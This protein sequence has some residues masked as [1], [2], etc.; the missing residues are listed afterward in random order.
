M[1]CHV[2]VILC[3]VYF[4][5]CLCDDNVYKFSN[6]QNTNT[7]SLLIVYQ[8]SKNLILINVINVFAFKDTLF[9]ACISSII[10]VRFLYFNLFLQLL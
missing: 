4:T 5:L 9:P 3:C 2:Y 10:L 1:S 6:W 7:V 8:I